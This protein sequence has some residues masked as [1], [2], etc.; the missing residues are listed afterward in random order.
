MVQLRGLMYPRTPVGVAGVVPPPPWHY[1][2]DMLTVEY[3]TDPAHVARF[4]PDGLELVDDDPGAVAIIWAEWQSCCDTFDEL[5]DPARA[6]YKEVFVVVRCTFEG[7]VYS[8]CVF[9]WV[10]KDFAMARGHLQGYPKKLGDIWMTRP[11]TV[12][13]AGPR[14]EPGGRFGGT[15][16]TFGRRLAEATFTITGT[17]EAPGFVNG[18]PMVH[19]RHMPSVECDGTDS[20]DELVTFSGY[21]ADLGPVYAGD[22]TL[23][24]LDAPTEE[25]TA[26]PV[27]EMIGGYFR[28]VG[29]SWRGGTTLAASPNPHA[30]GGGR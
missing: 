28:Q 16:S 19:S 14:L 11:V 29:V 6:Q 30:S 10:D 7:T 20:L 15:V 5:L 25:L 1:S 2:G 9:I 21:D 3:R 12:G 24:L 27:E 23:T 22:A 8:R 17:A 18:H 13:R 4:L 26:L